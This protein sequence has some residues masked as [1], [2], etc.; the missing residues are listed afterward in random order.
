[1]TTPW[2]H[3]ELKPLIHAATKAQ[4]LLN[5]DHPTK[6]SLESGLRN[7]FHEIGRRV[8]RLA[9]TESEQT[10]QTGNED[11]RIPPLRVPP[12]PP[13][14][15]PPSTKIPTIIRDDTEPWKR[16]VIEIMH[17]LD[18]PKT[19]HA[20]T[21]LAVEYG[22]LVQALNTLTTLQSVIPSH[23]QMPLQKQMTARCHQLSERGTLMGTP[24]DTLQKTLFSDVASNAPDY[25]NWFEDAQHWWDVLAHNMESELS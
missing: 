7:I 6:S 14:S 25:Q 12:P 5:D 8:V 16:S 21:D 22:R 17:L 9:Q 24:S 20:Y 13:V 15:H 23:I 19:L 1:M 4:K 3:P 2:E 18:T 10:E 11:V